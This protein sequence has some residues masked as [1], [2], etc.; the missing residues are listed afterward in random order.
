MSPYRVL[1]TGSRSW[2]DLDVVRDALVQA[3]Y[4][5]NG[6]MV[7]VHGACPTG[8][9]AIA[10]WWCR[11]FTHLGIT[12]ERHP[13]DW[14]TCAGP[15]CTPTHRLKRRDGSTYCPTAGHLR[16]QLMVDLGADVCL[17][18]VLPCTQRTCRKPKPHGSHGASDAI[19]RAEKAGIHVERWPRS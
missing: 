14:D 18:F 4:Q 13:A 17:A 11:R 15:K 8:A 5:A 19:D 6:P 10:D 2:K 12:R 16:N 3:R 9:D 1:I 7:V